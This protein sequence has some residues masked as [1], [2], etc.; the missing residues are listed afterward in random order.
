MVNVFDAHVEELVELFLSESLS[1][2]MGYPQHAH[3]ILMR[4]FEI[5]KAFVQIPLC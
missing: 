5:Q 1:L 2:I 4:V 3:V